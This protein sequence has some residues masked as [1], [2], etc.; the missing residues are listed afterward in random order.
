MTEFLLTFGGIPFIGDRARA[1]RAPGKGTSARWAGESAIRRFQPET[2]FVSEVNRC[3]PLDRSLSFLPAP[4]FP[5][6]NLSN[7]STTWHDDL[8]SRVKV[9][10]WHYPHTAQKWSAFRGLVT[11]SMYRAM[12]A[13]TVG[14]TP[15]TFVMKAKPESPSGDRNYNYSLSTSMYLLEGRPVAE[16]GQRMKGANDG[17]YLV[18]LVD[19]RYHWQGTPVILTPNQNT[20]WASL[21]EDLA[22]A[23]G[24]TLSYSA[25]PAAYSQPEPD[26]Q[27]W[28]FQE[29]AAAL[30]DA[31]AFN[32]GRTLVRD[33]DG[34]YSLLTPAESLARITSNRGD[35]KRVI[36]TMGGDFFTSGSYLK[37][38]D[39]RNARNAVI[40]ASVNIT[41][42]KYVTGDD[43]VPHLV[44]ER[45]AVQRPS[46]W[47][48]D[49]YGSVFTVT[50]PITSGG[51]FASGLSGVN[52]AT[53]HNTAKAYYSGANNLSAQPYNVSGLTSLALQIAGDFY[54]NQVATALDEVYEGTFAWEPD[55]FHDIIWLY[56]E[57]EKQ[58]STRVV[59]QEWN[60]NP[61]EMQHSAPA[62]SGQT[63]V[64][65]GVGGPSVA[66]TWRDTANSGT[67]TA[68]LAASL[69]SGATTATF[70]SVASLP[71]THRWFGHVGN[72]TILF[73]GTSGGVGV[74]I[75]HRGLNGTLT[76]DHSNGS[77]VY[78]NLPST[79]YGV[80]LTTF[81]AGFSVYPGIQSETGISEV[82]VEQDAS[83]LFTSGSTINWSYINF[84]YDF[85]TISYGSGVTVNV[86]GGTQN[87]TNVNINYGVS[88]Q[89]GTGGTI[90]TIYQTINIGLSGLSGTGGVRNVYNAVYNN[91]GIV[92]NNLSG[93]VQN[94]YSE[95][96]NY[97]SGKYF[98]FG[99][100]ASG[101]FG[102]SG[103]PVSGFGATIN[104][105]FFVYVNTPTSILGSGPLLIDTPTTIL[106]VINLAS[107]GGEIEVP[108]LA[109]SGITTTGF[110]VVEVV[111]GSGPG[112][113]PVMGIPVLG[114]GLSADDVNHLPAGSLMYSSGGVYVSDGAGVMT[115]VGGAT[116]G[117]TEGTLAATGTN[118][119]TAAQI[120]TDAVEVTGADGVKGV[121]LKNIAAA[122]I[123]IWNNGGG[124]DLFV[125]PPTGAQ[126]GGLGTNNPYTQGPGE[127]RLFTRATTTQWGIPA[128]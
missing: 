10:E 24:I 59:R 33:L 14:T 126:I 85:S 92:I 91:Y 118:Q 66:Q 67:V 47:Y 25:I 87:N 54:G 38:G 44:N 21:L 50:V 11:S 106:E 111:A 95:V 62:L 56:S 104:G 15:K 105:G 4:G 70:A 117:R 48:E 53:I 64:P 79:V 81:G 39:L 17:V 35:A 94:N 42:P 114:S 84:N 18:T 13:A 99:E 88:G 127:F 113:V 101:T 9:G 77:T 93:T 34:T 43:P 63:N 83:T 6:R 115:E 51:Q 124:S 30:L 72:E 2:D 61:T 23:L 107:S 27:L 71:T 40:P 102:A 45:Y 109:A 122:M 121:I 75:V 96:N 82:V 89:S 98:N 46:C 80:N 58:A 32:L 123:V 116:G 1:Y 97:F 110:F 108:P 12:L 90:S 49:G 60:A 65:R 76:S 52:S 119:A 112:L 57:R 37:A 20:T 16:H 19:D 73:E 128:G 28:E 120:V 29:N 3:I 68:T 36:R 74:G 41:Y 69:L 5:G 103:N 8:Q 100:P 86:N 31:V 7:L 125:Y 78:R 55:G 22:S 26:S